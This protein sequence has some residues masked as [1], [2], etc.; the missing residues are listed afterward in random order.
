MQAV[1]IEV[2]VCTKRVER[3]KLKDALTTNRL[4]LC[5]AM[6]AGVVDD[7]QLRPSV[8]VNDILAASLAGRKIS[9]WVR[10]GGCCACETMF[11]RSE[12]VRDKN[13]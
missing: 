13:V 1:N 10:E 4:W 6:A 9:T 5:G 12:H 3:I 7:V 2:T 8:R 11:R